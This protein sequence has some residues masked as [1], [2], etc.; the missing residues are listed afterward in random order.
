M[1]NKNE[2]KA[3]KDAEILRKMEEFAASIPG[4]T[5]TPVG[6]SDSLNYESFAAGYNLAM[7]HSK[8]YKE[9]ERRVLAERK[10]AEKAAKKPL[11]ER[12]LHR[13]GLQRIE[14]PETNT[15]EKK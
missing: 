12:I 3:V 9:Y 13:L 6:T 8:E 10:R 11:S 1:E 7:S 14:K 15:E 5:V 2:S 4:A